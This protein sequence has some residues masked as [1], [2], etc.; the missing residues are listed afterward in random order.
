VARRLG[1][2]P[3]GSSGYMTS[4]LLI[5]QPGPWSPEAADVTLAGILDADRLARLREA[6]LRPLLVRRPGRHPRNGQHR[7][8]VFVG[9]GH[10]GNHWLERLELTD[11]SMLAELDLEAVAMGRAGHGERVAGPLLL[12]CT[13][14]SKDMCCA[15]LGRPLAASLAEDHA[16]NVWEVSHVGGDR[17]AG[18]LLV[19]PDGFLHGQLDPAKA[20][21]VA[22]TAMSGQV[23]PDYLRGR[24]SAPTGWEQA[25]EIALR[26]CTGFAGADE[27]LATGVHPGDDPHARTVL[28]AARD[29]RYELVVRREVAP[30]A[31]GGRCADRLTLTTYA[32]VDVRRVDTPAD[33]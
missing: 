17:W 31:D 23:Y 25:A 10:P 26:R 21:L 13:H 22:K 27:V 32:V 15:V 16:E 30:A 12:V 11:L 4:W 14:G 20:A 7:H 18:N 2:D 28:V 19:V 5:E 24:T 6:G 29:H 8:T 9:S 3:A 33:S 1:G